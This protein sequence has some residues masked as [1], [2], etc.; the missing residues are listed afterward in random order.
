M[1]KFC[2]VLAFGFAAALSIPTAVAEG[3]TEPSV[4]SGI[5]V[6][7]SSGMK[8]SVGDTNFEAPSMHVSYGMPK[9]GAHVAVIPYKRQRVLDAEG[10]KVLTLLNAEVPERYDKAA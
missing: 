2:I 3:Y 1:K 9:A 8:V 5:T 6:L 4:V 10:Y 7:K